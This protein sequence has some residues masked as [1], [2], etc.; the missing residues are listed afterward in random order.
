MNLTRILTAGAVLA[1]AVLAAPAAK[2]DTTSTSSL[3]VS[4]SIPAKP[5]STS[6]L[7]ALTVSGTVN[8]VASAI[9]DP[10]GG[11]T[12]V[13]YYIDGYDTAKISGASGAYRHT[14]QANIERQL[15]V[16]GADTLVFT[17]PAISSAGAARTL[18]VTATVQMNTTTLALQS[19]SL[20]FAAF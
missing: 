20:S 17:V 10:A 18:Q 1:C 15:T 12:T 8:I 11:P 14:L 16:N 6:T 7:E 9:I 19:A 13:V 2:A 4:S 5:T 3:T